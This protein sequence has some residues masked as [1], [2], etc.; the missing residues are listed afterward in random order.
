MAMGRR[1]A[2]PVRLQPRL[3]RA[4]SCGFASGHRPGAARQ[5]GRRRARRRLTRLCVCLDIRRSKH[6]QHHRSNAARITARDSR[7]GSCRYPKMIPAAGSG[8]I[9]GYDNR[10]L[11]RLPPRPVTDR[12]VGETYRT[13][14]QEAIAAAPD[15]VL[16]TSWNEW[17]EGSELEASVEYGSRS[18]TLPRRFRKNSLPNRGDHLQ[19]ELAR[20]PPRRSG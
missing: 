5:P 18:L 16:I 10:N 19:R 13:L 11:W 7:L 17:H 12:W 3:A 8:I 9:P 2:R 15:Y 1:K 20:R 14:W 4:F 6:L